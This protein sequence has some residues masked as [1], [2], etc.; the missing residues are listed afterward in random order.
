MP[1]IYEAT[2]AASH[3]MTMCGHWMNR[4]YCVCLCVCFCL[5]GEGVVSIKRASE[6]IPKFEHKNWE[7]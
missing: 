4:V 5:L 6:L 1:G 7:S 3:F 2:E